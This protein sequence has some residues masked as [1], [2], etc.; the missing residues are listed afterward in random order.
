MSRFDEGSQL[1]SVAAITMVRDEGVMLPRWISHYSREVGVGNL[2]VVDDNSQDGSTDALPCPVIR[3]PPI[4]KEFEVARMGIV[5]DL[6]A[7]LLH[8]HDAVLFA[9]ADEF[10]VA[11][12]DKFPSLRHYAARRRKDVVG[13]VGLN[14][15]HLAGEAPLDPGSPVLEQRSAAKF[16][17]LM[18]KPALKRIPARW[19]WASHGIMAPYSVDPDLLM[20]H[21]KFADRDLLFDQG[22]HR[23]RMVAADGRAATTSWRLGG[24][25]MMLL[26]DR[27]SQQ[28][29]TAEIGPFVVRPRMLDKVVEKRP[30]GS[31]R[32]VGAGQM[33]AMER[34]PLV[35]VPRRFRTLV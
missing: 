16:L 28:A 7:M 20:F 9:D 22:E 27:I 12:P 3:L 8:A 2:V 13:V 30:D 25:E 26:L 4:T 5:S 18:C 32:A 24:S 33:T 21:L 31:W 34:R 1:P 14:V 15:V 19:R 17:P 23:R 29:E 6:A 11:D 35:G 10:L